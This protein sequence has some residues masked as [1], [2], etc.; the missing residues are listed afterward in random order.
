MKRVV[1]LVVSA[2]FVG[3]CASNGSNEWVRADGT[4]E[5]AAVS[6]QRAKDRATCATQMGAP[7][8]GTQS[9]GSFSRAQV[10]DCMRSR[11]WSKRVN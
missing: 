11:G 4:P 3:A 9:T 8:P 2:W 6:E 10:E 1:A 7:T 5:S